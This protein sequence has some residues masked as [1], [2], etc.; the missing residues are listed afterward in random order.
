[1]QCA[2]EEAKNREIDLLNEYKNR[3]LGSF[4]SSDEKAKKKVV[5]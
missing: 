4:K 3:D 2:I 1:M 5:Y